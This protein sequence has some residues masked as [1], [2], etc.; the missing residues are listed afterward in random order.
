MSEVDY[1][2]HRETPTLPTIGRLSSMHGGGEILR[3]KWCLIQPRIFFHNRPITL[4][5]FARH[6]STAASA[7]GVPISVRT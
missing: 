5:G 2:Q 4:L 6:A 7:S 3:E 1:G